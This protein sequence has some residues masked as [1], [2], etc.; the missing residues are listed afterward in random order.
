MSGSGTLIVA[1]GDL[2][3]IALEQYDDATL[4]VQLMQANGLDDPI[5]PAGPNTIFLPAALAGTDGVPNA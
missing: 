5:L 3:R 2:Y 1:G 4:A